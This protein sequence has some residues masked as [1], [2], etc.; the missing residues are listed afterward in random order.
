MFLLALLAMGPLK[1]SSQNQQADF[2]EFLDES[3]L[4]VQLLELPLILLE[5]FEAESSYFD[6]TTKQ[7]I[8]DT[9]AR[10]FSEELIT[11]DALEFLDANYDA[12]H[13][14]AVRD[15][16]KSPLT[17]KMND[18]EQSANSPEVELEREQFLTRLQTTPPDPNRVETIIEFDELTDATF[19]TVKI[20]TDLYMAL[21]TT[22][23][24]HQSPEDQLDL[25]DTTEIR[26]SIMMQLLPVYEN[27]MVAMN[28]FAYREVS[29]AELAE[30]ISFYDTDSGQWFVDVSYKIFDFV[31]DRVTQRVIAETE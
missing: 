12:E 24:P 31:I 9:V 2:N 1:A 21:I 29:D 10:A 28:L 30:Y 14:A 11:K 26:R 4:R 6:E 8:R 17:L 23:N 7:K 20:I 27:V 5:Q 3:G 22:M 15:W 25:N 18:Y 16:L 19:N 13:M